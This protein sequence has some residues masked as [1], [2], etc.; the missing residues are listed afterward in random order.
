[1]KSPDQNRQ[2]EEGIALLGL[3][4]ERFPIDSYLLY[5]A[6]LSRWNKAYNLTAIRDFDVM[7]SHHI[8]DSLSIYPYLRGERFLDVGTGAGLPGLVLAMA[9]PDH[10]WTLVDSKVKKV[11][12]L[13]HVIRTLKIKNTKTFHGRVEDYAPEEKFNCI[14]SRA[15]SDMRSFMDKTHHLV[16]ENGV[17]LAMKGSLKP[18]EL[19]GI[20]NLDYEVHMLRVPGIKSERNLVVI[21]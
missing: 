11:R 6:E 13:N 8:L 3:E 16:A 15:F 17:L 5:L 19:K 12:F 10:S 21:C 2:L 20:K 9:N 4:P 18:E 7:V 14:V 1:L